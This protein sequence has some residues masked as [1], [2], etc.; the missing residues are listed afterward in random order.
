MGVLES[1][2]FETQCDMRCTEIKEAS[3]PAKCALALD[4][5]HPSS[6]STRCGGNLDLPIPASLP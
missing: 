1:P 3:H 6:T 2:E 4:Q 5:G